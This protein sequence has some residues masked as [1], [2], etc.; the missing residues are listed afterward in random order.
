[1]NFSNLT[2]CLDFFKDEETC[3]AYLEQ[4]RW[5]G[6]VACPFCGVINLYRT[7]RGFKCREKACGKKFTVKVGTIYKNSKISL[8]IWFAI[9]YLILSSKKGVSNLQIHRQLG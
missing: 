2:E 7:N 1:M 9:S 3:I 4:Q 5:G 8:G 6:T